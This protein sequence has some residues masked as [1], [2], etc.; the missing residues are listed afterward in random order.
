MEP[1]SKRCSSSR[2]RNIFIQY[3]TTENVFLIQSVENHVQLR[4][5]YEEDRV[6]PCCFCLP[7]AEDANFT[8]KSKESWVV[9]VY[10]IICFIPFIYCVCPTLELKRKVEKIRSKS[11]VERMK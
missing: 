8:V 11:L 10:H 7:G 3:Y 2:T 4:N 6:F 1:N 5:N 9:Y